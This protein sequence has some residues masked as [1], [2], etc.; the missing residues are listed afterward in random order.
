MLTVNATE[1][2][3]DW[4]EFID[5][6]IREKPKVIKRSRDKIVAISLNMLKEILAIDKLHVTLLPENDGSVSAVIDE[7]DLT[8]NAPDEEQVVQELAKDA[9]E[10][11]NEFYNDFTYWYS[12]PN[13]RHH[14]AYVLAILSC[15]KELMAKELF[16]CQA[17]KS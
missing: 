10:Y 5:S 11:A 17:G 15:D 9:I 4:G 2:R 14:L 16:I 8:A 3:K 1:V 7:L 6:I 13:R 12:A